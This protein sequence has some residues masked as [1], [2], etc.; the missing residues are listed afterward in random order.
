M[1]GFLH[2]GLL[3]AKSTPELWPGFPWGSQNSAFLF[4]SG[5]SDTLH[6][7]VNQEVHDG[8]FCPW[9]LKTKASG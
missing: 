3:T 2:A 7:S 8:R 9:R 1:H 4:P 6:H 5:F